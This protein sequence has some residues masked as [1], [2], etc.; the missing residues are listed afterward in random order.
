MEP[1][2][3]EQ[4]TKMAEV[5]QVYFNTCTTVVKQ[6]DLLRELITSV[7]PEAE[8]MDLSDS[9]KILINECLHESTTVSISQ[10][11]MQQGCSMMETL[12]L[13]IMEKIVPVI[14]RQQMMKPNPKQRQV[15]A[16]LRQD[17]LSQTIIALVNISD[18]V[19][20]NNPEFQRRMF[21]QICKTIEKMSSRGALKFCS[22]LFRHHYEVDVGSNLVSIYRIW[23]RV[24]G[25][26]GCLDEVPHT[27]EEVETFIFKWDLSGKPEESQIWQALFEQ[28]AILAQKPKAA[29]TNISASKSQIIDLTNKVMLR[30]LEAAGRVHDVPTQQMLAKKAIVHSLRDKQTYLYDRLLNQ[31]VM[32]H[33]KDTPDY[34]LLEIFTKGM[35]NDYR[36]FCDSSEGNAFLENIQERAKADP[37]PFL[38][39]KIR[40]LTL[41]ELAGQTLEKRQEGKIKD[42][43]LSLDRLCEELQLRDDIAV[44][45]FVID[46]IR[47]NMVKAKLSQ[48][49]RKVVIHH[50]VPRQF[51]REHWVKLSQRLSL[52]RDQITTINEGFN[53][54]ISDVAP[55]LFENSLA[56]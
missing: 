41:I 12:I 3:E 2:T 24:A 21:E 48:R 7:N 44:E 49:E 17:Q 27:V 47:T 1:A 51:K 22:I 34:E 26:S 53:H 19:P 56:F 38:E 28:L 14:K 46:A 37:R 15:S 45:E 9:D 10:E 29:L 33:I 11:R 32:N 13:E 40:Q 23:L 20:S 5:P 55:R 50:A 42:P 16:V 18:N 43:S 30:M 31:R 8:L 4:Y 52:W 25:G 35:L 36:R 54:I 39:R 6:I